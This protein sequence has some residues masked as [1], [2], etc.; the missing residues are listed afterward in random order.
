MIASGRRPRLTDVVMLLGCGSTFFAAWGMSMLVVGR[1]LLTSV[2]TSGGALVALHAT[3]FGLACLALVLWTIWAK[4]ALAA[5]RVWRVSFVT[6]AGIV[7][8]VVLSIWWPMLR[9]S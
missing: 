6:V 1:L 3:S 7:I 9:P 5:G 8:L 4:K 2:A